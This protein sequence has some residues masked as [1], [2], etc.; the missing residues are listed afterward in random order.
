VLPV[1]LKANSAIKLT[2]TAQNVILPGQNVILPGD[3]TLNCTSTTEFPREKKCDDKTK[4][5]NWSM[6]HE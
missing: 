4:Q 2:W 1:N 3:K 5:V 6:R